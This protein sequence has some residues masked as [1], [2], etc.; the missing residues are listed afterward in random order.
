MNLDS[1]LKFTVFW[2]FNKI[3][4]KKW[5]DKDNKTFKLSVIKQS[6]QCLILTY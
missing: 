6:I 5:L 4:I 2:F 1:Y 3:S